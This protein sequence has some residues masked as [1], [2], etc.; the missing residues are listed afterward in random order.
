MY[1]VEIKLIIQCGIYKTY[2]TLP[3]T[4]DDVDRSMRGMG[5]Y[6]G[7]TVLLRVLNNYVGSVTVGGNIKDT[8]EKLN[9]FAEVIQDKWIGEGI[10]DA[11]LVLAKGD[12]EDATDLL[13]RDDY[14]YY[15][16]ISTPEDLGVLAV[17]SEW[18][19]DEPVPNELYD[20]LD[21]DQ[22]G[23]ELLKDGNWVIHDEVA[24]KRL[25]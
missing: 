5:V 4:P 17:D 13:E 25:C 19:F 10:Y 23:R 11:V 1:A 8:I 6:E 14:S 24:V 15:P 18:F 16:N 22:I 2:V 9:R 12:L 7:A 3:T 21:F 20:Y